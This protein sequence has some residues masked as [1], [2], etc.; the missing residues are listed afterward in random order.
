[1]HLGLQT[2]SR[3]PAAVQTEHQTGDLS[4]FEHVVVVS[5]Y[6]EVQNR[7]NIQWAAVLLVKMSWCERSASQKGNSDSKKSYNQGMQ[8]PIFED[9]ARQSLK[10]MGSGSRRPLLSANRKLRLQYTQANQSKTT[11]QAS[12]SGT[13]FSSLRTNRAL[14]KHDSQ[15]EYCCWR[16]SLFCSTK[17]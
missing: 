8:K 16:H 10:Q 14:F 15:P 7:D 3:R 9:T 5:T 6:R 17:T 12:G 11:V 2:Q 13:H 4:G 1:M